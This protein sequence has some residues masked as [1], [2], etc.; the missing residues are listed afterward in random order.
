MANADFLVPTDGGGETAG[1]AGD[2]PPLS[3]SLL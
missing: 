1:R 3:F 2:I